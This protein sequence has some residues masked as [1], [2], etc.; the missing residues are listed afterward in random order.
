[1]ILWDSDTGPSRGKGRHVF[2]FKDKVVITKRKRNDF[3][4]DKPSFV[5][6]STVEVSRLTRAAVCCLQEHSGGKQTD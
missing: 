4:T 3:P 2:L 1:M 6:K 5:F